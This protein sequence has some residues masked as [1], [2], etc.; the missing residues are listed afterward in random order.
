M[1]LKL[2]AIVVIDV[3]HSDLQHKATAIQL[4]AERI[5]VT[6]DGVNEVPIKGGPEDWFG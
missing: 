5:R 6:A 1:F 3:Y 4:M 2:I